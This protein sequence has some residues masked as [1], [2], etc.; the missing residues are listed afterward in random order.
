VLLGWWVAGYTGLFSYDSVM[1]VWQATTGN[2]ST[3]HSVL[4]NALRWGSLQIAGQAHRR[5]AGASA[6][7]VRPVA[8]G[9]RAGPDVLLDARIRRASIAWNPLPGPPQGWT[10]RIPITGA[11]TF[12]DV[13]RARIAQS[14]YESA[15]RSAPLSHT[16]HKMAVFARTASD[17]GAFEWIAGRG[18]TW[19]YVGYLAV[20][21]DARRRPYPAALAL[22]AVVAA[23]QIT[24]AVNTPRQ[25]VRDM[26]GPLV[27]GILLLPLAVARRVSPHR[28]VTDRDARRRGL[29]S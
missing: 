19:S 20:G 5:R 27:L 1:Y 8:A 16:A 6:A 3:D 18:A 26:A 25:L 28:T 9:R 14:P 22:I 12:F 11:V 10:R 17:A 24:V 7:A 21:L 13:P 2:W 15:I 4:C 29:S 23:T